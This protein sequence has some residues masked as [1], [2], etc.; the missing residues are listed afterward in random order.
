MSKKLKDTKVGKF[1]FSK[2]PGVIGSL[3]DSTPASGVIRSIIGGSELSEADKQIALKELD[4]EIHEFD[5]ITRRWVADARSGSWLSQNVRP[6]T[7]AF[8]TIA[9]ILGWCYGLDELETVA[10]LLKIVFLAYFGGRSSE[11]VFGNKM[12]K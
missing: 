8:L 12:H 4:K 1:L 3:L 7:L 6:L 10:E 9:F 2:I 11:K 5:G